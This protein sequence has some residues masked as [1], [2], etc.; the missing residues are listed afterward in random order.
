MQ[1]LMW[2]EEVTVY[3]AIQ[4]KKGCAG[5]KGRGDPI[6]NLLGKQNQAR[7]VPKN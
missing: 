2:P 3:S 4:T 6:S 7:T 1:S 5:S